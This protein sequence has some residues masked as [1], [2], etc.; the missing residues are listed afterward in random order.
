MANLGGRPPKWTDPEEL[1]QLCDKYFN[2]ITRT[3]PKRERIIVAYE[4][5]DP[6]KPIFEDKPIL[7]N[8][9]EQYLETEWLE[10]PT[11]TSLALFLGVDRLTLLNYR[12]KDGFFSTL[13]EA[14]SKIE[15]YE[16]MRLVTTSNSKGI[17]FSLKNNHDWRDAQ[18]IDINHSQALPTYDISR[19]SIE[20]KQR[21]LNLI[22]MTVDEQDESIE[23]PYLIEE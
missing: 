3:V 8:S 20:D 1:K 22:G 19:M 5:N 21:L 2:K 15:Q 17:E 13:R 18:T 11:L 23:V 12:N 14:K 6:K 4:D 16:S 7:D 9:G 10:P